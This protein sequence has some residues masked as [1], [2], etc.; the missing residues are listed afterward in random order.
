MLEDTPNTLL[1][2]DSVLMHA[3]RET[4]F[5]MVGS[6]PEDSLTPDG[7]VATN[8][9]YF[10]RDSFPE[11]TAVDHKTPSLYG[12]RWHGATTADTSVNIDINYGERLAPARLQAAVVALK[13]LVLTPEHVNEL[14]RAIIV[15]RRYII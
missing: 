6:T 11:L 13:Q 5:G 1:H 9:L 8:T 2:G 14:M 12:V 7:V 10:Y 3:T 4:Q 15:E